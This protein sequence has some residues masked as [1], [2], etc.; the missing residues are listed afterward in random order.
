MLIGQA[1]AQRTITMRIKHLTDMHSY[2]GRRHALYLPVRG[3]RT[4]T[5]ARTRK[6]LRFKR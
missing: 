4:R 5:N 1:K 3:Q 2:H 6:Q